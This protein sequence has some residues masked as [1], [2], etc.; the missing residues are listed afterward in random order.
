MRIDDVELGTHYRQQYGGRV[1][2]DDITVIEKRS[3]TWGSNGVRRERRLLVTPVDWETG[4]V[5]EGQGQLVLPARELAETWDAHVV[6]VTSRREIEHER[7][8]ALD[9]LNEALEDLPAEARTSY[10]GRITI[11]LTSTQAREF[12]AW[13]NAARAVTPH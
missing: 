6:K 9:A 3:Y 11:S 13:I 10:S 7:Q 12:A 2:V 5:P 8:E 4:E 1:R